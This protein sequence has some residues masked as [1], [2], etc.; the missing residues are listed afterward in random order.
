MSYAVDGTFRYLSRVGNALEFPETMSYSLQSF[1]RSGD[2]LEVVASALGT[3]S[4]VDTFEVVGGYGQA[5]ADRRSLSVVSRFSMA[6]T[7]DFDTGTYASDS[8]RVGAPRTPDRRFELRHTGRGTGQRATDGSTHLATTFVNSG[9]YRLH[10][11]EP[12]EREFTTTQR[13]VVALQKLAPDRTIEWVR[14]VGANTGGMSL[15]SAATLADGSALFSGNGT[16]GAELEGGSAPAVL[17]EGAGA[18]LARY[19]PSGNLAW[20]RALTGPA[21]GRMYV[22]EAR[23]AL[24]VLGT[25]TGSATFGIGDDD[26]QTY[27]LS[28]PYL[29]RLS[30]QTGAVEWLRRVDAEF[31]RFQNLD[32]IGDELVVSLRFDDAAT[33]QPGEP[34][35]LRVAVTLAIW[36]GNARYDV[37]GTFL[38]LT[39]YVVH[40]GTRL[41]DGLNMGGVYQP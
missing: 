36:S 19:T 24:F 41:N 9:V 27:E 8:L 12:D 2:R 1:Q 35:E 34:D 14:I 30:L 7:F 22:D 29:A 32:V 13:F 6:A 20:V 21:F 5:T 11:G 17:P 28:G 3:G 40:R 38:G 10:Q 37:N 16:S 31:A 15:F 39:E 4:A 33:F 18:F 25:G 26:V 23:G